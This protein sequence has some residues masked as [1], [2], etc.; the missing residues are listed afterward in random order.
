[1][2]L[3][4]SI[5]TWLRCFEAAARHDSFTRAGE[6]LNLSQGA[7]SQQIRQLEQWSGCILFHRLPRRLQLTSQGAQLQTEVEPAL[8]RI[9]QAMA[10][11]R[12]T[13]APIHVNCSSSFALRWLMPR[14]GFFMRQ[15]PEIDVRLT[16]EYHLLDRAT[17]ARS[18]MH[19]AIRYDP[20]E[21]PDLNAEFLMEDYLLP[22]ASPAFSLEHPR[23]ESAADFE[24]V[25]L[26]HDAQSWPNA[27]EYSEW[28]AWLAGVKG[29]PV[30]P[31]RGLKFNLADLAIAAALAGDGV[32]MAGMALVQDELAK[33]RLV[34]L[35]HRA[36]RSPARYV[37]LTLDTTDRRIRA[38][39]D[40]LREECDRFTADRKQVLEGLSA[41][42]SLQNAPVAKAV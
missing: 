7:V 38:F 16:A 9:E 8:R 32:A 31:R 20:F 28:Q 19:V 5:L 26:L 42:G 14:L 17:F 37:L 33:G 4:P 2:N 23:L 1:M 6:E 10:A 41:D 18:G 12:T 13:A 11:L 24:G 30:D 25:T 22:V 40:W 29:A 3:A 36:V 15:H 35:S 39:A 27:A 21:H 34:P